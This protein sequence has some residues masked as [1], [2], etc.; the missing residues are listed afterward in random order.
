MSEPTTT[1]T[2]LC[3]GVRYAIRPPFVFFHYCYCSRCRRRSGSAHSANLM[4]SVDQLA[5]LDGEDLVRRFEL[6]EARAFCSGFC[7]VC[8]SAVPWRTRNGKWYVVPAGGLDGDPG[9]HPDKNIFFGSR[10]P[11]HEPASRLPTLEDGS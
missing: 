8:G 7:S 6:P 4:L 5:W 3:G 10:A 1:G 11:W 2:C 9:P